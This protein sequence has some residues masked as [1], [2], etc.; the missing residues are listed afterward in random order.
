MEEDVSG[1]REKWRKRG[2]W[3][4]GKG[5]RGVEGEMSGGRDEWRK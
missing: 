4:K 1:G 2:E 3:R 5:K